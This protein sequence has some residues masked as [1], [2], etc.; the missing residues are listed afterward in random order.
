M[1]VKEMVEVLRRHAEIHV[2]DLFR[3][4]PIHYQLIGVGEEQGVVSVARMGGINQLA[5]R[6]LPNSVTVQNQSF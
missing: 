1:V 3:H 4:F 5:F 2:S 6:V